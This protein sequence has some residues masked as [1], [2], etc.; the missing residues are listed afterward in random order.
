MFQFLLLNRSICLWDSLW[1][2]MWDNPS[3]SWGGWWHSK[4]PD[5]VGKC[6]W[7]SLKTMITNHTIFILLLLITI[8]DLNTNSSGKLGWI[9]MQAPNRMPGICIKLPL[10][11]LSFKNLEKINWLKQTWMLTFIILKFTLKYFYKVKNGK[12]NIDR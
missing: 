10:F 8:E 3:C 5:Y 6:L 2:W 11:G 9:R 1:I 7:S 12:H 4:L